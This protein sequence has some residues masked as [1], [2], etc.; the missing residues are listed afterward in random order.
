MIANHYEMILE[1]ISAFREPF[2]NDFWIIKN[3]HVSSQ[4]IHGEKEAELT[5]QNKMIYEDA[6]VIRLD[7]HK[8]NRRQH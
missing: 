2:W 8:L 1:W 3:P 7:S 4:I 6:I 5:F